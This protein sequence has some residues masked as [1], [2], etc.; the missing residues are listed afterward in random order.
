MIL[1]KS[2]LAFM[3]IFYYLYVR[4]QDFLPM[5]LHNILCPQFMFLIQYG[6]QKKS[7]IP[8]VR[9]GNLKRKHLWVLPESKKAVS[10]LSP[11]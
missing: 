11:P 3:F 7:V 1:M 5:P 6:R 2:L 8:L 10:Y 9:L 4:Y